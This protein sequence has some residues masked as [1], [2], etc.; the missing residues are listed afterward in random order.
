MRRLL[1]ILLL[2][3][4][5]APALAQTPTNP[6]NP[7]TGCGLPEQGGVIVE[8]VTTYNLTKNC[9]M[10]GWLEIKTSQTSSITLTINGNNKTISNGTGQSDEFAFLLVDDNGE[11]TLQN[12]ANGRS[13]NVK[14]VIKNVTF[15]G[16]GLLFRRPWR[17][18][19][20]PTL[21]ARS[22]IGAWLLV[23]G[24]L[25]MENVTFTNGN[26]IWV[27][28][29]GTATLTDV[30]FENSRNWIWGFGSQPKGVLFVDDTGNVTLNKA[31]FRDIYRTVVF[32]RR[33]GKLTTT[34][35]LSFI[36]VVTH[37]V[38]HSGFSSNL[39]IWSDSSTGPCTGEIGNNHQA[40]VAYTLPEL[41]CGLPSG[42]TIEGTVVYSLTQDCVC[43]NQITIAAGA[44]VTIN[45][46]GKVIRGCSSSAHIL[47]G[48]AHLTIN[49]AK[50]ETVRIRNYGGNFTLRNSMVTGAQRTPILNYGWAYLIDSVFE[51]NNTADRGEGKVYY[52]H[53]HFGRGR[54]LFQDNVFRGNTPVDDEI[55]AYTTGP[56]TAIYLCGDNILEGLPEDEDARQFA[57]FIAEEGGA[58]FGCNDNNSPAPAPVPRRPECKPGQVLLPAKRAL[59]AIGV[60][61]YV[62]TCPLTIE[63]WE[64][65]SDSQGQFA[66][67]VSQAEIEAASEGLVACS[68]NGRAAVR[69]GLTEPVRQMMA[70]SKAYK[71]PS[72]R[73]G[74]DIQISVGPTFEHKVHH[75]VIDH[76]LDGTVMGAIDTRPDGPPCH[77]ADASR[78]QS[79]AAPAAAPL[80]A[81]APP[82]QPTPIPIAA[83][84][85]AQ[86]ARED[87]S[88][89]HVV[90]SGDTIWAI[91]VAYNVHPYRIISQ[92][93]LDEILMGGGMIVPG[94]ELL[95]RPAS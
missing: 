50:I 13:P 80:A 37:K 3:L 58:I 18:Q 29:K 27:R 19:S 8:S 22:A 15:D 40:V 6:P 51:G 77:G 89:V 73:G 30:L 93:Q 42:G 33:G 87:G 84:V 46:N 17:T 62:E 4:F 12:V 82:P 92:N 66:L 72:Q 5:A 10:T 56:T 24:N 38:S 78:L 44:H 88:I 20:P 48:D 1:P 63:I 55:E 43:V 95:I 14:V 68:A 81:P 45:G 70:Y 65:Q 2:F 9:T 52:G 85:T 86:P 28:A 71:P 67:K 7:E 11:R 49:N 59:G 26:G 60:I 79:S 53:G 31:V 34:G 54:A 61:L 69:V 39:G 41:P 75:L 83:P 23:D 90:R 16:Q 47:V 64:I 21:E 57:L 94:Q 32:I 91:G 25:E 35:C 36:R 76:A 74:R